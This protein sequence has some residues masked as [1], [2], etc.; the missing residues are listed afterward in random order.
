MDEVGM[1]GS[2][3]TQTRF[4]E[5]IPSIIHPYA[6][7]SRLSC[8]LLM[9]TPI[10]LPGSGHSCFNIIL[11]L[12]FESSW[13]Y[14][15]GRNP[16]FYCDSWGGIVSW[17]SHYW[18][19]YSCAS[20]TTQKASVGMYNGCGYPHK[21]CLRTFWPCHPYFI[22]LFTTFYHMHHH[23]YAATGDMV[24]SFIYITLQ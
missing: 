14:A 17:L 15:C 16:Y 5:I 19:V 12:F 18:L 24:K 23:H 9:L 3:S 2:K 20:Y 8:N 13:L 7:F 1:A 4:V 11:V 22:L 21:S 10:V 6:C